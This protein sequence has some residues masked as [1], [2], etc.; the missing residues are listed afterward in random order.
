MKRRQKRKGKKQR[1]EPGEAGDRMSWLPL[2]GDSQQG[3]CNATVLGS[4]SGF[5]SNV[6]RR[7]TLGKILTFS[8]P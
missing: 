5:S 3:L 4:S 7:V 6:N 2:G 1:K 8:K